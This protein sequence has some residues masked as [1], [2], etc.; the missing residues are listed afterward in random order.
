M[1]VSKDAVFAVVSKHLLDICPDIDAAAIAPNVS[2]KDL[3][4]SSLDMVEVVS[5]AMRELAVRIS[6]QDMSPQQAEVLFPRGPQP[7][8]K[9]LELIYVH[10]LQGGGMALADQRV[11]LLG[12]VHTAVA[13]HRFIARAAMPA[14]QTARPN[15]E[16]SCRGHL[17]FTPPH[18][19][20]AKREAL[21]DLVPGLAI[22]RV[23][24]G[25]RRFDGHP[26][27]STLDAF[28]DRRIATFV[29]TAQTCPRANLS[30][31]GRF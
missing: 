17:E 31:H 27:G 28:G 1:S 6:R 2:M 25:I 10:A 5:C 30:E 24:R 14:Q 21:T 12:Q 16:P 22:G 3:G 26:N 19:A 23:E 4:A 15:A 13:H 9:I 8:L 18:G 20:T 7:A 11:F 29:E